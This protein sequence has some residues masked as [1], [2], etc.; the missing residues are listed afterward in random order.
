MNEQL[1]QACALLRECID[2]KIQDKSV[3]EAV[4]MLLDAH[5]N[6]KQVVSML[7]GQLERTYE[8]LDRVT[9]NP[10]FKKLMESMKNDGKA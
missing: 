8:T 10:E 7:R 1:E 5:E 4:Y 3:R 6:A 2:E 9:A